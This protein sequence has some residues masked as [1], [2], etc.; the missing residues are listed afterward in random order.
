MNALA[1]VPHLP[2]Q[3]G[4]G[5]DRPV[6]VV[7]IGSNSVR[8]V[9]YDRISRTPVVRFNEKVMCA[10]GKGLERTGQLSPAGVQSAIRTL[11]RFGQLARAMRVAALDVCATE[12]SRSASNGQEF[13][14]QAQEAVGVPISILSGQEEAYFTAL[15]V[16]A[17]FHR[18]E[19]LVVDLGG[20]SLEFA[21]IHAGRP[22]ES[23][24]LPLGTLRIGDRFAGDM[25]AA[26]RHVDA[27]LH[28]IAAFLEDTVG[29]DLFIVGGGWRAIARV[30][31]AM[32]SG[33]LRVLHGFAMPRSEA[34][35]F[36]RELSRYD[37][38]AMADLPGVP[39][40][41]VE[42]FSQALVLFERVVRAT[43]PRQAVFSAFG[44]REGRLIR[45]LADAEIDQDPLLVEAVEVGR[46]WNRDP[47]MGEALVRWTDSLFP[48]EELHDRRLRE[49]ACHLADI[50]WRDH[51][52][53]RAHMILMALSQMPLLALDHAERARLAYALYIRQ[54]GPPGDP[55]L[56]SLLS[57]VS[58]SERIWAER[59][60]R[61]LT[62]GFR[63]SGAVAEILNRAYVRQDRKTL[64]L[65]L[66][67]DGS[68][69]FG[70]V[71]DQRLRALARAMGVAKT[72]VVE[73][74]S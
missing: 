39:K 57:L 23:I 30:R 49:A 27:M 67:A 26:R 35:A 55:T 43:R 29:E 62:L 4:Q 45:H 11:A 44:L 32:Q 14:R 70:D 56:A 59:L 69:P 40:R 6:A 33:P 36:A 8:L 54:D 63:L 3:A 2:A 73:G 12:A 22:G 68:M 71:V 42:T 65:G 5:D 41:R 18:P 19:G 46:T 9:V 50:G 16:R 28:G 38:A 20:G 25:A 24:S 61:A 48:N 58:P 53:A 52:D 64:I 60:G 15:G 47:A 13:I 17:G 51:P 1:P 21:R 31:L 34:Q 66:P 74:G 37:A 72:E 10:L 7:D